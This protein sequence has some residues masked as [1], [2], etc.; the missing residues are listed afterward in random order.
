M[1]CVGH[2]K[3]VKLQL[4]NYHLK[5]HIFLVDIGGC[6]IM[7][8][9][10]WLRPLGLVTMDFKELYMSIVKD[11]STHTLKGIQEGPLEVMSSN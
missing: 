8:G 5:T 9:V 7:L 1:K 2:Y 3:N 4:G 6:D 10:E 11:S